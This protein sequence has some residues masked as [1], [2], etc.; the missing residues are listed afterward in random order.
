MNES[1]PNITGEETSSNYQYPFVIGV[2]EKSLSV[3]A[4]TGNVLLIIAHLKDPLKLFQTTSS[5]FILNLAVVDLIAAIDIV[6]IVWS[7][8]DL[9]QTQNE[10]LR[11]FLLLPVSVCFP[12]VFS[13]SVER[14]CSV[15]FPLWHRANVTVRLCRLCILGIWL[16]HITFEAMSFAVRYTTGDE[17]I[18]GCMRVAYT[19]FFFIATQTLYLVT[20]LSLRK[21]TKQI[22]GRQDATGSQNSSFPNSSTVTRAIQVRLQNEKCFLVTTAIICMVLALTVLPALIYYKILSLIYPELQDE[23]YS[24]TAKVIVLVFRVNFTVNPGIYLWR[25]KSYRKTFKVL[26]CRC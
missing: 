3:F 1:N 5:Q 24:I 2:T 13:L 22:I 11:R 8:V 18:T 19:S 23:H 26:Y 7:T 15:A 21:Q 20:C 16:F 4:V 10:Y 12:S 14:F 25:L 9:F 17:F 6:N